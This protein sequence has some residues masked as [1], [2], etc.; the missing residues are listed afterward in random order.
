MTRTSNTHPESNGSPV[1]DRWD[2]AIVGA[3]LGGSLA[4]LLLA[5]SG[6]RVTVFERRP[7][8]RWEEVSATSMNLGLSRRGIASLELLGLAER[9][10]DHAI[11]ML[12]RVVHHQDAS[13]TRQP[14]GKD[15]GEV[16]QAIQRSDINTIL[17]E[18]ADQTPGVELVFGTTLVELDPDGPV[19]RLETSDGQQIEHRCDF[20]VGAD[21]VFSKVR[22]AIHR[23]RRATYSQKFLRWGW[24]ELTIPPGPGGAPQLERNA[25]HLWPRGGRMLFAHPNRDGSFTCSLVLPYEGP[26]S[27]EA[28]QEPEQ[29]KSFFHAVFPDLVELI[30]DLEK[31]FARRP[32]VHL[33]TIR[34]S[35]WHHQ[36]KVVLLGDAAHAVVPFYA[37]GM[38]AAF[39]DCA[40]L[41]DCLG[42]HGEDTAAAF[43][44]YQEIRKPNTDALAD[45]SLANFSELMDRVRSPLLRMRKR[46]DLMLHKLLGTGWMTQHARVTHTTV[47]YARAVQITRRQDRILGACG[48]GSL[49]LLGW[50]AK[51]RRSQSHRQE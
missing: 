46:L 11:P 41:A 22:R 8:P 5:R 3:G 47:P 31:Q 34:T 12:G 6:H 51:R 42:R 37:Q 16:I 43:S 35:P 40:I 50:A 15:S 24:K 9:A 44:E 39:E 32:L 20:V 17:V 36:G 2:I 27:F 18:A 26:D 23:G 29:V 10:L 25:F 45:M 14:Y 4:A 21:G 33:P 13:I 38:N 1:G 49:L 7:D 48:I 28:L 30:P 19:L